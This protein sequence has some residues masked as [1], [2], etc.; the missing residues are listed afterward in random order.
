[1][2]WYEYEV[3]PYNLASEFCWLTQLP[4]PPVL[5]RASESDLSAYSSLSSM[6][7]EISPMKHDEGRVI[8]GYSSLETATTP[9]PFEPWASP[10]SSLPWSHTPNTDCSEITR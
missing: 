8:L 3:V 6:N 5:G 10:I 1:M 2:S 7:S 9:Q 4:L